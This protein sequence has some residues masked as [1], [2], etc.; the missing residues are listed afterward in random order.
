[1]FLLLVVTERTTTPE[2]EN[3]AAENAAGST[4]ERD[5]ISTRVYPVADLIV[6]ESGTA[7]PL[8]HVPSDRTQA[9]TQATPVPRRRY[10][11]R[12][13]P[14]TLRSLPV[15]SYD[16]PIAP[17]SEQATGDLP[18]D[19][20]K[21]AM[22]R[23]TL[24]LTALIKASVR[25]DS[26][27]DEAKLHVQRDSLSLLVRQTG[28]GHDQITDLLSD[29]RREQDVM[30]VMDATIIDLP[31]GTAQR[32]K[33]VDFQQT[34]EGYEWGLLSESKVA[35]VV[36]ELR[37]QGGRILSSPRITTLP[38]VRA[39]VSVSGSSGSPALELATVPQLIGDTGLMRLQFEA[40]AGSTKP[41]TGTTTLK[42]R[43]TVLLRYEHRIEEHVGGSKQWRDVLHQNVSLHFRN[44][45]LSQVLRDTAAVAQANIAIDQVALTEVGVETDHPVSINVKNVPLQVALEEVLT[46]VGAVTFDVKN[47]VLRVT[48]KADTSAVPAGCTVIAITPRIIRRSELPV[49]P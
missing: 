33:G 13:A 12:T 6:A 4:A 31:A 21:R 24:A 36:E 7:V 14:P 46:Q 32:L 34:D 37:R 10:T 3:D 20:T 19:K 39:K 45:P 18:P 28:E 40:A 9:A 17:N 29:L 47:N 16:L 5:Q 1:M 38:S 41:I 26:W 22:E 48:T 43:Q 8:S 44:V 42:S 11:L 15:L 23:S 25:P 30:V 49:Q 35:E 2:T 27:D